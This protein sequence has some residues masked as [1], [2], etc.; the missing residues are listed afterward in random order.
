MN[1]TENVEKMIQQIDNEF[2]LILIAEKMEESLILLKNLL[3]WNLEDVR[4]F[5]LNERNE[6]SKSLLTPE[7]RKRLK[8][9]LWADYKLYDFF[10]KKLKVLIEAFGSQNMETQVSALKEANKKLKF[11]CHE[12]HIENKDLKG[13]PYLMASDVIKGLSLDSNCSL[14]AISEPFFFRLI[15]AKQRF[16]FS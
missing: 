1:S 16:L 10:G 2:H 3:C 4:Y 15:R 14:Y 8:K 5:K 6:T 12:K 11:D 13:T 9:W 7:T